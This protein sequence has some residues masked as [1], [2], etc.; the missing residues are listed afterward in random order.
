MKKI[1]TLSIF[2]ACFLQLS[3]YNY[4]ASISITS[5][6]DIHQ[7]VINGRTYAVRNNSQ[8]FELRNL[9]QG[10]HNVKVYRVNSAYRNPMQSRRLVYE[11]RVYIRNGFHTE[12]MINRFGRAYVDAQRLTSYGD[13]DHPYNG[14]YYEENRAISSASFQ[15]L[16]STLKEEKFDQTRAGIAKAAMRTNFFEA[17]QVRDLLELFSFEDTKLELAKLFYEVTVDKRNYMLVYDVFSF[18]S[19]KEE[20]S[21]F[22]STKNADPEEY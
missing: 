2:L 4:G 8:T 10:Y 3:A 17:R 14:A 20:L 19:S 15:Q 11:G 21:R 7:V 18:S 5:T 16:K 12:V 1:F 9:H 22:L 6:K 13:D